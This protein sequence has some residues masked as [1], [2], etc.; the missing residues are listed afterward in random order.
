LVFDALERLY[1]ATDFRPTHEV[2]EED[3]VNEDTGKLV[4][5]TGMDLTFYNVDDETYQ[6]LTKV[7]SYRSLE[8]EL[9]KHFIK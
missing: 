7:F 6:N 2:W 3:F 1:D 8:K 4:E 9:I 5:V